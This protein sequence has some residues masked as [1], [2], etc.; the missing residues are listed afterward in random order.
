VI[1]FLTVF[2]PAYNEERNLPHSVSLI[3]AKLD[4]CGIACEILIV[5]DGS[6]DGT[7][8]I[9][10]RLADSMPRVRVIHHARNAGIGAA[11]VTAVAQTRGEWFILIPSD[12]ALA[13]EDIQRYLDAASNADIVIG[14][15]SDR[16]DYTLARKLVSWTNIKL[17]QILFGMKEQQFQYIS[18]YRSA[19]L[20][21]IDIEYARSAFFHAETIIKGKA[22]GQRIVEVEIK[23]APRVSGK[24]TGAKLKLILLTVRDIFRFW[25]KWI[26]LGP[27]RASSKLNQTQSRPT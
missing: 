6:G 18:M 26:L 24:A 7:G 12:L 16:S 23:Y 2:I 13:P 15:R 17:I 9:A 4:E 20:H 1:P 25:F 19:F 8:R 10:D 27:V 3:M 11:F 22:L 14:L 5:D 21:M